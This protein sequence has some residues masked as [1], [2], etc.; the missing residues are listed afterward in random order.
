MSA[1]LSPLLKQATPVQAAS[2]RGAVLTD[3]DGGEYLDFTSARRTTRPWG[4][5]GYVAT[6]DLS[7]ALRGAARLE[8]GMFGVNVGVVSN[9]AAPFG[10]V[11]ESGLGREGGRVG[12]EEHLEH[13]HVAI[14]AG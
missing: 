12:I 3:L 6:S 2:G 5:V 4:L 7:R 13:R 11:K 14:P 1:S 10:G 9:P 8:V